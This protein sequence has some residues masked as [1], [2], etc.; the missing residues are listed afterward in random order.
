MEQHGVVGFEREEVNLKNRVKEIKD[1]LIGRNIQVS[2][3]VPDSKDYFFRKIR[4]CRKECMDHDESDHG[5]GRRTGFSG[6]DH[7]SC[8]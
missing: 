2:A 1:A 5:S 4:L 3:S 7:C 8:L 6:C